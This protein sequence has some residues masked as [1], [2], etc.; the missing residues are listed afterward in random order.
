MATTRHF[1]CDLEFGKLLDDLYLKNKDK[2]R[3]QSHMMCHL[4]K[5]GMDNFYESEKTFDRF[6]SEVLIGKK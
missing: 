3:N 6:V 1:S 4:L 2:W 5:R